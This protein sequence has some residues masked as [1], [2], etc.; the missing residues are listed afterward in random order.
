[1]PRAA[2]LKAGGREG[3]PPP[4]FQG[5]PNWKNR[6]IFT[7]DCLPIM[8]GMNSASV[9]LI[10]LDPPFNTKHDYSAPIGSKAAGAA[11]KDTWTLDD[12]KADWLDLLGIE[13]PPVRRL[14]EAIQRNSDKAYLIYMAVRLAEM[15]RLLKPTGSI[16]LHCDPT[17]SHYLK[18]V[19]DTIYGRGNFRN[20]VVWWYGGGGASKKRWGRKHDILIF[21]TNG[22]PWTFNVDAVREPHKWT[23]GQLR[24]DGSERSL[25]RGKIPDDVFHLHSVM[26]WAKERTG[27]P[28]QKPLALLDRIVKASSN[29]GDTVLDPFCGCATACVA[30]DALNRQWAGIDISPKAAELV[31]HRID[32][33]TRRIV[34]RTDTPERTDL[35]KLPRYN[36][37]TN[38]DA[39]YAKQGSRCKGCGEE[40]LPKHLEVDHIVAQADGGTD[41][42]TN[43]QLL[44]G[45]CNKRKGRRGM[46]YLRQ[47][48]RM[49][50]DQQRFWAEDAAAAG[51]QS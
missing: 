44:C 43:L 18:V 31:R 29:E 8:R 20:E 35:G 40:F 48:L 11:F 1:M 22:K 19:M 23:N 32:D 37:K 9:D 36:S 10:Y 15:R 41:H 30:A 46:A 42:L 25:A 13:L 26:P 49:N 7:G 16:Y 14:L 24:A 4:E 17:M 47:A 5:K 51:R 39:L 27:Y 6:T 50:G 12:V 3:G 28:T 45:N 21:Y 34:H 33:L 2:R 38:K